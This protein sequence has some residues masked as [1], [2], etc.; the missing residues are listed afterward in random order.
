MI[1]GVKATVFV[2]DAVLG[3]L[4]G[5]CAK[6][7][8]R[9]DGV[10]RIDGQVRSPGRV[11]L[12]LFLFLGPI[13]W[14]ILLFAWIVSGP[15]RVH[16]RIP[17]SAAAVARERYIARCRTGALLAT[18]GFVVLALS[19]GFYAAE[20]PSLW[21][22]LAATAFVLF[23]ALQVWLEVTRVHVEID[24]SRRWITLSNVHPAFAEAVRATQTQTNARTGVSTPRT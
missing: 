10:F 3:H 4:P 22:I 14:L 8:E 23:V 9:A 12:L 16:T 2:D 5:V 18:I 11:A 20:V 7:G 24:G 15:E 6:T 21:A 19:G 17:Y 13:G 1:R